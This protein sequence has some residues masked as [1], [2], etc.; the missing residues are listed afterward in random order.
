MSIEERVNK[1]SQVTES[2][3]QNSGTNQSSSLDE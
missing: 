2:G 1:N 3:S